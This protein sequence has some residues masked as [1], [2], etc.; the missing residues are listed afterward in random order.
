MGAK[1]DP[2]AKASQGKSGEGASKSGEKARAISIPRNEANSPALG[3]RGKLEFG[4]PFKPDLPNRCERKNK[5]QTARK[6]V[7]R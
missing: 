2:I 1:P 3:N 6:R 7:F 4:A 5:D